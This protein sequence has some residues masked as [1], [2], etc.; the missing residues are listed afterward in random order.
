MSAS[1]ATCVIKE[2]ELLP[3]TAGSCPHN[4]S[5]WENREMAEAR[6]NSSSF[7]TYFPKVILVEALLDGNNF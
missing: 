4:F 5:G 7:S 2:E 1:R 6:C 3:V